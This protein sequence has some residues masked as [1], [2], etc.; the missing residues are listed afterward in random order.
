[1]FYF[2]RYA[3]WILNGNINER[4]IYIDET[5]F[6]LYTR[7]TYGRAAV[8]QRVNRIV[9]SQRGQNVTFIV[10]V[11][12]DVGVIYFEVYQRGVKHDDVAGF[13]VS[14][15]AILG[16]E[17]AILLLDNAPSHRALENPDAAREV[18]FLPAHS[19]FLNPIENCFSVLKAGAKQRLAC[20][21]GVADNRRLAQQHNMGLLEWRNHVLI[22]EVSAS[23]EAITPEIVAANYRHADSYLTRCIRGEHILW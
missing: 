22:R 15:A 17:R 14:L 21:Q 20:T 9:G 3:E 18:R 2:L 12:P 23:M 13:L 19:P 10:A 11:T 6:N 5:G 16:D 7:R 8:G 4:R 1:M